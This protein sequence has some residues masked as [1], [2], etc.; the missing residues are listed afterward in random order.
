MFDW[1]IRIDEILVVAGAV[2]FWIAKARRKHGEL[3]ES[4]KD[5]IVKISFYTALP[6]L[7]VFLPYNAYRLYKEERDTKDAIAQQLMVA[8]NNE[9]KLREGLADSERQRLKRLEDGKSYQSLA[10]DLA[11]VKCDATV[12]QSN[13]VR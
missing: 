1:I 4:W 8:T 12:M 11:T 7:L 9:S 6:L 5:T 3:P 2:W 13:V 10:D